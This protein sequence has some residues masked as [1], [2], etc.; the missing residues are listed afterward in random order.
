MLLMNVISG[1]FSGYFI[2][3]FLQLPYSDYES[4]NIDNHISI[5]YKSCKINYLQND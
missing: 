3:F 2:Y 5:N 4:I 1:K